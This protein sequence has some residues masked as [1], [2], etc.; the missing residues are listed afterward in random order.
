[1]LSIL[2]I[3]PC[4]KLYFFCEYICSTVSSSIIAHKLYLF[5]SNADFQQGKLLMKKYHKH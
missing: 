4:Q 5:N 3:T 2:L 1:M